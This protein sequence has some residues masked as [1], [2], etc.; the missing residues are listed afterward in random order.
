EARGREK[1]KLIA[2]ILGQDATGKEESDWQEGREPSSE[3]AAKPEENARSCSSPS[4]PS[5]ESIRTGGALKSALR[6]FVLDIAGG[7]RGRD[8]SVQFT[9]RLLRCFGWTEEQSPDATIPATVAV[10]ANAK[11]SSRE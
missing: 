1:A 11:R 6:R 2:R 9:A 10:V 8:A 7:L 3:V 5:P 4:R